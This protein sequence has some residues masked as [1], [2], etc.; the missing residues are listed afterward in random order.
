MLAEN[1]DF[2]VQIRRVIAEGDLVVCHSLQTIRPEVPDRALVDIFRI[3]NDKIV[4][5]WDVIEDIPPTSANSN[6]M[7]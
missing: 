2:N 4:E 1:P 3:E 6:G 7:V 5:H